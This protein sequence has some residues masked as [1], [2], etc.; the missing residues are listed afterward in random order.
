MRLPASLITSEQPIDVT[1]PPIQP[2]VT[3]PLVLTLIRDSFQYAP[4]LPDLAPRPHARTPARPHAPPRHP[5][6]SP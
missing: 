5:M 2:T 3:L 4:S 6:P 1:P